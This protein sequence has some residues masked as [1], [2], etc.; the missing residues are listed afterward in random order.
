MES[1]TNRILEDIG[2]SI[3]PPFFKDRVFI[4]AL[5][6]GGLVWAV[7]WLTVVPTFTIEN[8]SIALIIFTTV[9]WYPVLEEILFRGVIQ[10]SLIKK[11]FGQKKVVGL[12]VANWIAS[13][14]FVIAH[15][16]YQP[17]IWALMVIV[18]SLIYGFFRD[19]YSNTY[20]SIVL[21][22]FYNGGF[23]AINVFAQLG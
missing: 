23:T 9:V 8:R 4:A 17:A 10:G 12:T 14:L 11:S 2:L 16:W 19:R 21:H 3:W 6:V 15:L 20:P 7:M 18:P 1:V 5:A 22:A 13:L